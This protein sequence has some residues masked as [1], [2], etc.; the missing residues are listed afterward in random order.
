MQYLFTLLILLLGGG[1]VA[2][3]T[4][5]GE[6]TNGF[7]DVIEIYISKNQQTIIDLKGETVGVIMV[8]PMVDTI[9]EG[10]DILFLL[11]KYPVEKL[12][13]GNATYFME[14]INP[15]EFDWV[16]LSTA[17]LSYE[18]STLFY[19]KIVISKQ[20]TLYHFSKTTN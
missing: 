11:N 4:P 9:H 20:G 12:V 16:H 5:F 2:Q 7:G 8:L 18:G 13:A 3:N 1:L 6:Y 17:A 15:V 10:H 19:H 14:Q